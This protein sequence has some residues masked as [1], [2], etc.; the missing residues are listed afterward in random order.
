MRFMGTR[1]LV[2]TGAGASADLGPDER[3]PIPMMAQ[4][5]GIL[6]DRLGKQKA[7]SIG[8]SREMDGPRFESAL[9]EFLD[10]ADALDRLWPLAN[11]TF[12]TI[13]DNFP[14]ARPFLRGALENVEDIVKT[15]YD[16]LHDEFST[17]VFDSQRAEE[18]WSRLIDHLGVAEPQQLMVATTNYDYS[19]DLG[20][21][22]N[23]FDYTDG[24]VI[25]IGQ[26]ARIDVGNLINMSE[27]NNKVPLLQL[28]G[29]VGWLR[30]NDDQI[31][32]RGGNLPYNPTEGIPAILL[33]RPNKNPLSAEDGLVAPIWVEFE[34]A[35]EKATHILIIGHSLNDSHLVDVLK[36][37]ADVGG[38]K[39]AIGTTN[40][41]GYQVP[42]RIRDDCELI[43]LTFGANLHSSA[44]QEWARNG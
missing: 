41:D 27:R 9:G 32:V 16:T 44:L 42:S 1:F 38:R 18:A 37:Y 31:L 17:S 11:D 15:I 36:R 10:F 21:S 3:S 28:H 30:G 23:E 19:A 39:T 14:N 34:R 40:I 43:E 25:G 29:K 20:L 35:L 4:W 22:R 7:Q 26:A 24:Q 12:S 6:F 8:L 5:S 33:P 13:A 2:I